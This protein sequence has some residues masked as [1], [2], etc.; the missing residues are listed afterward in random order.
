MFR[1]HR[2][3]SAVRAVLTALVLVGASA[4]ASA[5]HAQSPVDTASARKQASTSRADRLANA[6]GLEL[7]PEQKA[8]LAAITNRHADE[9]KAVGELFQTDP[10]AAMKRM[11]VL[12]A[13]MQSEV[14]AVLT[15][16]QRA[17]FDRNVAEMNAQMD[18][19][20][21]MAPR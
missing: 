7:T 11:V 6:G 4:G 3:P 16:D 5:A 2:L 20:R 9:G 8:K 12:R 13:K 18:A 21:P 14:R 19:H 10:D 1:L 17:I 15:P